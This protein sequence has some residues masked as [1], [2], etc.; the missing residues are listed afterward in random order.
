MGW[1]REFLVADWGAAR[2]SDTAGLVNSGVHTSVMAFPQVYERS[3]LRSSLRG[4]HEQDCRE[5]SGAFV[6]K[7]SPSC[8]AGP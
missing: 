6:K 5:C 1:W 8:A 3:S 4:G 7:R 2:R